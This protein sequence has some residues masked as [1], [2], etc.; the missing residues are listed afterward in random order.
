MSTPTTVTGTDFELSQ[1]SRADLD[2]MMRIMPLAS[3][4]DGIWAPMM[5]HVSP[6]DEHARSSHR[7]L[8]RPLPDLI[9]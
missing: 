3:K 8:R 1:A 2:A 9:P 4:K 7:L 6:E 5:R